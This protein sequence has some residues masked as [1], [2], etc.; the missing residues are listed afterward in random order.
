MIL[1]NYIFTARK[2]SC[3]KVM[4]LQVSV[5]LFT[6]GGAI[7]ACIAGG[8]PACRAA[9][10]RG[11]W[12]GGACSGGLLPGGCLF[13]GVPAHGGCLLLGGCLLGGACS[14]GV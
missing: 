6:G 12:P 1:H 14:Q 11:I 5:I 3:G 8:I 2:R 4:F 9:G 7:P 10:L 13:R